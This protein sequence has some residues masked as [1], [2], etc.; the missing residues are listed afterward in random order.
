MQQPVYQN[1]NSP[2]PEQTYRISLIL[3]VA[4]IISQLLF[5]LLLYFG[6]P[7]LFKFS[8]G[9]GAFAGFHPDIN[10]VSIIVGVLGVMAL[11]AFTLSFVLK[12]RFLRLAIKNKNL[13]FVQNGLVVAFA[14]CEAVSL[15]GFL[16]AFA[17]DFRYFFLWFVLGILGL[18]LH[19]PRRDSF[20]AAAFTGINLK[21]D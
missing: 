5:L 6:K 15:F 10:L 12:A 1:P 13:D 8:F 11:A 9:D 20:Q 18:L 3:W 17:F 19:F 2:N 7:E 14:L 4:M 16:T 21:E